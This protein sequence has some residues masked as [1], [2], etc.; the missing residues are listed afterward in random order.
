MV[1][2]ATLE[3]S[4]VR[5][6]QAAKVAKSTTLLAARMAKK[7]IRVAKEL[8]ARMTQEA[9]KTARRTLL[10][11]RAAKKLCRLDTK[12]ATMRASNSIYV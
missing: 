6:T 10:V 5:M 12:V 4:V 7:A 3:V 11:A 8:W 1:A 9:A 2:L